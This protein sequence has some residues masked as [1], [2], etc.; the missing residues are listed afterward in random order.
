[1]HSFKEENSIGMAR[2]IREVSRDQR[3]AVIF[4]K[5]RSFCEQQLANR[6]PQTQNSPN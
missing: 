1:M 3:S 5:S 2:F 6:V 4:S